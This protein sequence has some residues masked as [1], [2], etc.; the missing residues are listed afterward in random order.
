MT[1]SRFRRLRRHARSAPSTLHSVHQNMALRPRKLAQQGNTSLRLFSLGHQQ[2]DFPQSP[3]LAIESIPRIEPQATPAGSWRN[4]STVLNWRNRDANRRVSPAAFAAMTGHRPVAL[5]VTFARS[6][7]LTHLRG[8]A[9]TRYA[10]LTTRHGSPRTDERRK[11]PSM[12]RSFA[13]SKRRKVTGDG[14][15]NGR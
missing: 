13:A 8:L 11:F 1:S 5:P 14:D 4:I 9:L 2:A 3:R 7:R 10:V 15:G 6:D 12:L